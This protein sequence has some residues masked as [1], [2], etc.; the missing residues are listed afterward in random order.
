MGPNDSGPERREICELRQ[1]WKGATVADQ[2]GAWGQ[3]ASG[4][5]LQK[6]LLRNDRPFLVRLAYSAATCPIWF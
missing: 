4:R 6:D 2:T 5:S 3:L 1:A